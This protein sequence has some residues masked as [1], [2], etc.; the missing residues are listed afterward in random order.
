LGA[1][2]YDGLVSKLAGKTLAVQFT[3]E[4]PS[5]DPNSGNITLGM[6][7]E[8]NQLFHELWH[9]YQA[10]YESASSFK[11]SPLNQDFEAWYAQYLYISKL[12]EYKEGSQWYRG[13]HL[14]NLGMAVLGLDEYI[15]SRGNLLLGESLLY[16]YLLGDLLPAFREDSEY[17]NQLIYRFDNNRTGAYNFRN[18]GYLI[19]INC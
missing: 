18:L 8:S 2:L 11:T 4:G 1:A 16:N 6:E 10:Y 5:F 12:P 15:N 14:T 7:M 19:K 13:Y 9:A 3:S 17:R